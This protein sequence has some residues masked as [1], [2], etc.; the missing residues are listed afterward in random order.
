MEFMTQFLS[1]ENAGVFIN[2]TI[3][4]GVTLLA[5]FVQRI[6]FNKMI[7][8]SKLSKNHWDDIISA[9]FK[10]P[11]SLAIWVIGLS[12]VLNMMVTEFNLVI[13]FKVETLRSMLLIVTGALA[14]VSMTRHIE[15]RWL[16]TK[17]DSKL[18]TVSRLLR[19]MVYISAVIMFLQTIG[20]SLSG[21]M[22]VGGMSSIIIGMAAKDAFSSVLGGIRIMYL[23]RPF[24]VGDWIRSTA[25]D[26][27]GTVTDINMRQVTIRR[28]NTNELTIPN[29]FFNT[30]PLENV[31]RMTNRRLYMHYGIRYSDV[32][33]ME[34]ITQRVHDMLNAHPDVDHDKILI[35]N[36]DRMSP[37]SLDFY[38]YCMANT[39]V[40]TEYTAI[41]QR[42]MLAVMKIIEEEGAECAFPTT[43]VH[44]ERETLERIEGFKHD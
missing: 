35:V 41:K 13:G 9:S 30:A 10:T 15:K 28:F 38:H 29:S 31:S 23:D 5:F 21:V 7:E 39:V 26:I 19:V 24:E 6:V 1:S 33:K 16:E 34:R 20:V 44:M 43:T 12:V 11:V 32:S 27:E 37:S 14:L 3:V 18:I 42:I 2:A 25:A 8:K 17:K 40:W 36:F 22:A 4:L